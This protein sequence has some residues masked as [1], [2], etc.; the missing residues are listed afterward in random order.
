MRLE[1]RKLGTSESIEHM[2]PSPLSGVKTKVAI[3]MFLLG[4]MVF[5]GVR[6]VLKKK[7]EIQKPQ[8]EVVDT[9]LLKEE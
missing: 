1:M 5:S 8:T 9:E 4:T 7:N 6:T 3:V 2:G